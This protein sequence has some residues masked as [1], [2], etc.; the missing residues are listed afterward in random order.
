MKQIGQYALHIKQIEFPVPG[1]YF[2]ILQLLQKSAPEFEL[3][4]PLG[5]IPHV[6]VSFTMI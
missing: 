3:Y 5:Q 2:P 4:V 1:E 6:N